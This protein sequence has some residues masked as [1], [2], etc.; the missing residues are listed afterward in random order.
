MPI[1]MGRVYDTDTPK[2][3]INMTLNGVKGNG[4][5]GTFWFSGQSTLTGR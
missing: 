3:R 4:V 2:A 5:K 1:G